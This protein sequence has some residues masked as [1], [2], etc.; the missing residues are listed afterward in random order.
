MNLKQLK[1]NIGI[2]LG[3]DVYFT[4]DGLDD[5]PYVRIQFDEDG[6]CGA[7]TSDFHLKVDISEDQVWFV[8]DDSTINH[9]VFKP[10]T[11][12]HIG[13]CCRNISKYLKAYKEEQE[14]SA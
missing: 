11:M 3:V 1:E 8:R 12:W 13:E 4:V 2:E 7:G 6:L 14:K 9:L 5:R 10:M